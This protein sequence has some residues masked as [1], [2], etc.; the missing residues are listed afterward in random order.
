ML[1]TKDIIGNYEVTIASSEKPRKK[2]VISSIV[3]GDEVISYFTVYLDSKKVGSSVSSEKM[4][5]KYNSL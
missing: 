5:T 2:L 3:S 1:S 4:L